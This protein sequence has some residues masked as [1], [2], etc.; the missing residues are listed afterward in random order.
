MQVL[1]AR[2]KLCNTSLLCGEQVGKLWSSKQGSI[3]AALPKVGRVESISKGKQQRGQAQRK[4]V[5]RGR[6]KRKGHGESKRGRRATR[7]EG[8][9]R[10]QEGPTERGLPERGRAKGEATER[11][12]AKG[13][14]EQQPGV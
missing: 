11:G 6:A 14:M 5:R 12:M 7:N 1:H 9:G 4:E 13:N 8:Q 2:Q 3:A 10:E